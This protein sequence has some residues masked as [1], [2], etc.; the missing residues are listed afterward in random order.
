[1][2]SQ[3]CTGQQ[4]MEPQNRSDACFLEEPPSKPGPEAQDG[5]QLSALF[6]STNNVSTL[7]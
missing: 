1:M 3:S 4:R 5:C 2:A 6:K 7:K